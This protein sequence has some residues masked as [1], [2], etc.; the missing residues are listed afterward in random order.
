MSSRLHSP[1]ENHHETIPPPPSLSSWKNSLPR[2][3]PGAQKVGNH[4]PKRTHLA[5]F[6]DFYPLPRPTTPKTPV[7][8]IPVPSVSVLMNYF[9]KSVPCTTCIRIMAGGGREAGLKCRFSGLIAHL[10]VWTLG[11]WNLGIHIIK[12]PEGL[13]CLLEFEMNSKDKLLEIDC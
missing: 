1:Y 8:N 3:V 11:R 12:L 2:N 13:S 10:P 6:Q 4:C 5:R 7:I 9:L